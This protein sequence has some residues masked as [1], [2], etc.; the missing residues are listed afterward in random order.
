MQGEVEAS[1][2]STA[3]RL[4]KKPA[5]QQP[6]KRSIIVKFCRR[7]TKNDVYRSSRNQARPSQLF[8]NESLSPSRRKIYNALREMKRSNPNLVNGC[9]TF[10]GKIYAYTKIHSTNSQPQRDRRHL[11]SDF[12]GLK[13]FCHEYV[14]KPIDSF[15][16]A[17][18]NAH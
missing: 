7:D 18:N 15:L 6:D 2:I 14:K 1:E 16:G 9:S 3:H 12:D 17:W 5:S 4:G 11:I 8:I 13:K 10:D